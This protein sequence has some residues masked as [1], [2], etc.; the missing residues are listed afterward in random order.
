MSAIVPLNA[1]AKLPAYLAKRS[2]DRPSI[3]AE[4]V[5]GG[6]YPVLSIK[7]KV[8]TL[9]KDGER[10]VLTRPDDPDEVLQNITLAVVRANTKTRVYYAKDFVEGSEGE[11]AKPDCHSSDGV[12]P[13][14]DSR[15][16]QAKKC[17][18]CPHAVWG[19]GK[20]GT[21][22][23]CAV[24]TRL[25][26]VD[27]EQAAKA[28]EL[29]PFLLRVPAGS[30]ANFADVV[31]AADARGID[32]NMLALKVGFDKE[33]PAPKLTFK[34]TGLLDEAVYDK[35]SA[36]YTD[37]TV[38]E[39]MGLK[40]VAPRPEA[41]PAPEQTTSTQDELD[42][43]LAAKKATDK[44]KAQAAADDGDDTPPAPKATAKEVE[45]ATRPARKTAATRKAEEGAPAP[46]PAATP[47]PKGGTD[48]LLGDLDALLNDLDD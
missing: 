35:V 47:A 9:V 27:P 34:I 6:G 17:Q 11:S 42:A 13:M 29:E 18:L 31:K 23:A 40:P 1:G 21:G 39:M 22:T 14:A 33:A 2:A 7:G 41:E 19:T 36:K 26:V 25:A 45:A 46:A 32:Y 43:I 48:D 16:P 38:L 12:V 5:T 3:N 20:Q 10:K 44:A 28:D 37:P 15:S 8:F 24:N 4:V 30:R